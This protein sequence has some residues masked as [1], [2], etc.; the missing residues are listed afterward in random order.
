[1][2]SRT[3]GRRVMQPMAAHAE[4]HVQTCLAHSDRL[5]PHVSMTGC[6]LNLGADV[7]PVPKLHMRRLVKPVDAMPENLVTFF[8]VGGNF[9]DFRFIGCNHLVAGHTERHVGDGHIRSLCRS[10][11]TV[12]TPHAML[13]VYLVSESNRL[14][15][16]GRINVKV[17]LGIRQQIRMCS[18]KL[19]RGYVRRVLALCMMARGA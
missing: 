8:L 6:T 12:G 17:I 5:C 11:V 4:V 19:S 1:M 16:V 10:L 7:R 14:R 15:H 9:L 3:V 13:Q 18:R 2:T